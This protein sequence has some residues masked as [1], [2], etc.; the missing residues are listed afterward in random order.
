[1]QVYRVGDRVEC[2]DGSKEWKSGTVTALNPLI[3]RPDGWKEAADAWKIRR[4]PEAQYEW[5]SKVEI[6]PEE[7]QAVLGNPQAGD[8]MTDAQRGKVAGIMLEHLASG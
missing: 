8:A 5:T 6:L 7:M 4:L 3:V 1:M 2:R